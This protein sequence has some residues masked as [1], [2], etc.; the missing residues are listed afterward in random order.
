MEVE[1]VK[2]STQTPPPSGVVAKGQSA[3][4]ADRK[5]GSIDGAGLGWIVELKL[6]IACDVTS[7]TLRVCEDTAFQGDAES[8]VVVEVLSLW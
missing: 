5:A 8:G 2:V 3:I 7:A 4:T 1:V 6:L